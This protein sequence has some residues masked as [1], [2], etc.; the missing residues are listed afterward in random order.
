M[1]GLGSLLTT[2]VNKPVEAQSQPD[3]TIRVDQC[4]N[5]VRPSVED[6]HQ[7]IS[8]QLRATNNRI[9][10]LPVAPLRQSFLDSILLQ[11]PFINPPEVNS[12]PRHLQQCQAIDS[13]QRQAV[14]LRRLVIQ[15]LVILKPAM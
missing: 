9:N 5:R 15:P 3:K 8:L 7:G 12:Q 2:S 4:H 10:P 14:I 11:E 13:Y 6:V 1:E